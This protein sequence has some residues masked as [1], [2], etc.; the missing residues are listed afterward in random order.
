MNPMERGRINL[1]LIVA[2][3]VAAFVI[4]TG[5][6]ARALEPHIRDGWQVGLSYGYSRGNITWGDGATSHDLTGG[7]TPQIRVGR[8][9]G[10]KVAFGLEYHGW[11]LEEAGLPTEDPDYIRAVR[12]SLQSVTLTGTWYPGSPGS[13]LGGFYLRGG[14]GYAWAGLALVLID[15]VPPDH[16]PM[17]Q[18]H[19]DRVDESG[20][21]LNAQV[22]YEFRIS[23]SFATGLGLGFDHLSIGKTIYDSAYYVPLTL[24]GIWYW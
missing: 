20:L 1:Q 10:S 8:M 17:E 19:G 2:A 13:S 14:V 11:M 23:R 3:V 24:T 12:G 22:G 18:E 5:G 21:A 15:V 16:V 6:A 7:S 4:G 9:V